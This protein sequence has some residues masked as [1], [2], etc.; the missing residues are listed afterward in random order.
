[1]AV[2]VV[3]GLEA[4]EVD[5]RHAERARVA[6]RA[7]QLDGDALVPE[8]PVGQAGERVS[9]REIAQSLQQPL[10][11]EHR[12]ELG[13]QQLDDRQRSL[14]RRARRRRPAHAQDAEHGIAAQHGTVD[15]RLGEVRRQGSSPRGGLGIQQLDGLR[16][17][18][19]ARPLQQHR[20][21]RV[22]ARRLAR[23]RRD[24][25]HVALMTAQLLLDER[26]RLAGRACGGHV[27]QR[28]EPA[29]RPAPRVAQQD[30]AHLRPAR[31][32]AGGRRKAQLQR[33]LA[34][35]ARAQRRPPRLGEGACVVAVQR[36]A[37]ALA[38]QCL[39]RQPRQLAH[40]VVGKDAAPAL[41]DLDDP[42]R[43][44]VRERPPAILLGAQQIL[45][46]FLVAAALDREADRPQERRAGG[47]SW[48]LTR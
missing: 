26:E 9:P 34:L 11:L 24:R 33:E 19:A 22:C 6:L 7:G 5:R 27:D 32:P 12:A 16:A 36:V 40:P 28:P 31:G 42:D 29:R 1:M 38:E 14:T 4:I 39:V 44:Q 46:A 43:R 8:P 18:H 2:G 30:A 47:R 45:V 10:L 13:G 3:V 23:Q 15:D 20:H 25:E 41:I 21:R 17:E 48:P 37:P 35:A